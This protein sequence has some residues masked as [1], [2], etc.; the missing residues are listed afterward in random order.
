MLPR[1]SAIVKWGSLAD[2]SFHSLN[3]RSIALQR[4]ERL[5]GTEFETG[6]SYLATALPSEPTGATAAAGIDTATI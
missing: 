6:Q 1:Y 3:V 5:G 2:L 4:F